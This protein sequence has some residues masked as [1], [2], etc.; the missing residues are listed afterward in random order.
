ME[1]D[2]LP[3]FDEKTLYDLQVLHLKVMEDPDL[4]DQSDY[5]DFLKDLLRG[6]SEVTPLELVDLDLEQESARL[7]KELQDAK[8][9]FN[10]DDHSEKMAYFRVSTSLLDKLVSMRERARH[11]KEISQFY[12]TVLA[13]FEEML[14]PGQI[15]E[16]R[17]RLDEYLR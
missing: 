7:F 12:R 15:T 10:V 17:N 14:E 6:T 9:E 4:L 13:I 11:V 8:E 16:V 2:Y 3:G 1:N 5:P